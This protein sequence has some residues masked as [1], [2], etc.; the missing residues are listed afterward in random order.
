MTDSELD[1]VAYSLPFPARITAKTDEGGVWLYDWVEQDLDAD[2]L[3]YVDAYQGRD[4]TAE[5]SPARELANQ[6]VADADIGT[7][8]VMLS[9]RSLV[10]GDTFYDFDLGDGAGGAGGGGYR[11]LEYYL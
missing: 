8:I 6:E 7:K 5:L 10:N 11:P 3:G 9:F 2:T 4:G 1:N